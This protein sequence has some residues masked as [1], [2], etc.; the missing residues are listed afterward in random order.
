MLQCKYCDKT[1]KYASGLSRHRTVEHPERRDMEKALRITRK[2]DTGDLSI[3]MHL[4]MVDPDFPKVEQISCVKIMGNPIERATYD[5]IEFMTILFDTDVDPDDSLWSNGYLFIYFSG[6]PYKHRI[7]LCILRDMGCLKTRSLDFPHKCFFP[8]E[9]IAPH[10]DRIQMDF[11]DNE[12]L[13][14]LS[15]RVVCKYTMYETA[16]RCTI[17]GRGICY[18]RV[19][20]EM[21]VETGQYAL[22]VDGAFSGFIYKDKS[23]IQSIKLSLNGQ[24]RMDCNE[25][26]LDIV[27]EPIW[28][29]EWFYLSL[30][31]DRF[32]NA[33]GGS[34]LHGCR[35]DTFVVDIVTS[36]PVTL[37]FDTFCAFGSGKQNK[38]G[39]IL[40]S[41]AQRDSILDEKPMS[42]AQRGPLVYPCHKCYSISN[43]KP[44]FT[45]NGAQEPVKCLYCGATT[46]Q[47][48]YTNTFTQ[49]IVTQSTT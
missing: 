11:Y 16:L 29:S 5:A 2:R 19:F 30:N 41:I 46:D 4:C 28:N 13:V 43:Y 32:N 37:V 40:Q 31:G 36:A 9:V 22:E 15:F 25:E 18:A 17:L 20:D 34:M 12:E 26:L 24:T 10:V 6:V 48:Y 38:S 8:Q 45:P 1:F 7:P 47:I 49:D 33:F 23:S 27:L 39:V 35:V 14:P 42:V 3:L 44:I 21:T